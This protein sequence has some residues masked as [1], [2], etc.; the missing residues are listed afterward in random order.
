MVRCPEGPH[1]VHPGG[2]ILLALVHKAAVC[3]CAV[4]LGVSPCGEAP[5]K[6]MVTVFLMLSGSSV[7]FSHS[8]CTSQSM[9][10]SV[11]PKPCQHLVFSGGFFWVCLFLFGWLVVALL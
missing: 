9:K 4:F 10:V 3:G 6:H 2:V 7:L 11:S 5:R 1:F 8:G